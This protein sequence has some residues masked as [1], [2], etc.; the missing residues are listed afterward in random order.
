MNPQNATTFVIDCGSM[1]GNEQRELE[2]VLETVPFF[3]PSPDESKEYF[4]TMRASSGAVTSYRMIFRSDNRM[5]RLEF[6]RGIPEIDRGI[7][8]TVNGKKRRRSDHAAVFR[9]GGTGS[10][11]CSVE[12]IPINS[13]EYE[14]LTEECEDNG[15]LKKTRNSP[16]GRYF[17]WF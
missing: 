6:V 2:L 15:E 8:P 12:F 14:E 5:W 10:V 3:E 17:G 1:V 13:D 4:Y 9:K 11:F 16:S 7:F